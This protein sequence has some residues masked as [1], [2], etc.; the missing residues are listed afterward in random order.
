LGVV[1]LVAVVLGRYVALL[2][3]A[4]GPIAAD[5]EGSVAIGVGNVG[6]VGLDARAG[7]ALAI[8]KP[9]GT[10]TVATDTPTSQR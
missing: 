7:V 4:A 5:A 3:D 9:A 10:T 6:A 8:C 1:T 2:R